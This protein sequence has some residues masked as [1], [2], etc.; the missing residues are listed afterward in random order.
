MSSALEFIAIQRAQMFIFQ[1][2]RICRIS[3]G[4]PPA[5]ITYEYYDKNKAY[6]KIGPI[7]PLEFY[8]Q[9]CKPH[10]DME[11]KVRKI[12]PII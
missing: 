9:Y 6:Q 10:F 7:S 11:N 4:T 2:Y 1:I 8:K 3:L 5:T 12:S